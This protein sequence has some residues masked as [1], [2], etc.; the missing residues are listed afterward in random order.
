MTRRTFVRGMAAAGALVSM[1][2]FLKRSGVKAA[3]D[4]SQPAPAQPFLDW[5]GVDR[6]LIERVLRELGSRGADAADLYFQHQRLNTLVLED[7]I[8]SR[9]S[10]HIQQGVGLRSVVGDQTGYAFTEDISLPSMLAAAQTAAAIA[11]QT[12]AP[13]RP[14]P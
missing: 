12:R 8:I 14:L 6:A 9:A 2:H 4:L 10:S 5:F 3:H 13:W 7:G 11:G 1:P